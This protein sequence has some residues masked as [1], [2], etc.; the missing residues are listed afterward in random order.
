ML[1]NLKQLIKTILVLLNAS[2]LRSEFIALF[3]TS[4]IKSKSV[5]LADVAGLFSITNKFESNYKRIQRFFQDY[6]INFVKIGHMLNKCFQDNQS[7]S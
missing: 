3:L 6:M 5:N 1:G 2:Y 7:M 4:L